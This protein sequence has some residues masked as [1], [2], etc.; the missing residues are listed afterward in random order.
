MF[1]ALKGMFGAMAPQGGNWADKLMMIG[2]GLSDIADGEGPVRTMALMDMRRQAQDA[3][4]QQQRM[5]QLLGTIGGDDPML[6]ALAQLDPKGA[7][8]ALLKRYEPMQ[9]SAGNTVLNAPGMQGGQPYFAPKYEMSGDQAV[10]FDPSGLK[11]L[12]QRGPS[13]A[14]TTQRQG[15]DNSYALGKDRNALGWAQHRSRQAAGGYGTP[16]APNYGGGY[17]NINPASGDFEPE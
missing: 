8:G 13:Y 1:K 6:A 16:G 14:E 17:V 12:G 9:V 11:V 3:A 7:A 5:Q 10:I 4:L 2:T 15:V